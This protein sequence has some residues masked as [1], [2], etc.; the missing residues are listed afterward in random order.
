VLK[1]STFDSF[2][3]LGILSLDSVVC[4]EVS[5]SEMSYC[6]WCLSMIVK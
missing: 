4:Y 6:M 5:A 3:P 1:I 2:I